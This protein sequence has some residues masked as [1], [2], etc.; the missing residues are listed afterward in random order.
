VNLNGAT[1]FD[2]SLALAEACLGGQL[3]FAAAAVGPDSL[4]LDLPPLGA[5]PPFSGIALRLPSVESLRVFSALY[6]QAEMDQTGVLAVTDLLVSSRLTLAI[7]DRTAAALL[8]NYN[9]RGKMFFPPA[10][11]EQVYAAAFGLGNATPPNLTNTAFQQLFAALCAAII[12]YVDEAAW[13][14][15]ASPMR[16]AAVRQACIDLMDNLAGRD[17]GH[18]AAVAR[19]TAEQ[20]RMAVEI[21]SHAGI[22]ALFGTRGMWET[23]RRIMGSQTPDLTRLLTRAQSGQRLLHWTQVLLPVLGNANAAIPLRPGEP[24]SSWA[25]QWMDATGLRVPTLTEKAVF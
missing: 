13:S 11:R 10:Q 12:R 23:L 21:L 19:Q 15:I 5:T 24:V 16:A 17:Y 22:H 9:T 1:R 25:S 7:T 2:R 20:L 8:E 18:N 14:R 4:R 6:F 3:M